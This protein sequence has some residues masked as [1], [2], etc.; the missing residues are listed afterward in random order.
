MRWTLAQILNT[1]KCGSREEDSRYLLLS[2]TR[3]VPCAH[4]D[5]INLLF[6][7]GPISVFQVSRGPCRIWY[8]LASFNFKKRG[9]LEHWIPKIEK[10]AEID[11]GSFRNQKIS[12]FWG[13]IEKNISKNCPFRSKSQKYKIWTGKTRHVCKDCR[14]QLIFNSFIMSFPPKLCGTQKIMDVSTNDV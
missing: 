10:Y 2:V 8:I 12:Q 6:L 4:L 9:F 11:F 5:T 13:E 7:K 14:S 1:S 3:L